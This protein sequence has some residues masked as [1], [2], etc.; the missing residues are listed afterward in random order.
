MTLQRAAKLAT[1][2]AARRSSPGQLPMIVNATSNDSCLHFDFK[3]L[4]AWHVLRGPC[5][6]DTPT[7]GGKHSLL[8]AADSPLHQELW[9]IVEPQLGKGGLGLRLFEAN[10]LLY[11]ALRSFIMPHLD[12]HQQFCERVTIIVELSPGARGHTLHFRLGG[13][14]QRV[15]DTEAGSSLV[16]VITSDAMRT[17]T[18]RTWGRRPSGARSRSSSTATTWATTSSDASA[19]LSRGTTRTPLSSG[20]T[21]RGCGRV[22][23]TRFACHSS[24]ATRHRRGRNILSRSTLTVL[25]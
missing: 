8:V 18:S 22:C 5:S 6:S 1:V 24:R 9:D 17:R 12:S 21:T 2:S 23:A 16:T 19:S 10:V 14:T 7:F 4:L 25:K 20:C 15:P 11:S 3:K 13:E